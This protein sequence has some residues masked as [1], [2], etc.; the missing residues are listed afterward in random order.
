MAQEIETLIT[1]TERHHSI[2]E[3]CIRALDVPVCAAFRDGAGVA[4]H[5]VKGDFHVVSPLTQFAISNTV[6]SIA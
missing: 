1:R 3:E 4:A 5:R 6:P 2:F